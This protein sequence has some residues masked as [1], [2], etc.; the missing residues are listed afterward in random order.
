M[1]AWY[2]IY[3]H[4]N[5]ETKALG[6]LARQGFRA[7]LPR[8]EK[9]RRHAGRVETVRRPLFPRYLFVSLDVLHEPWRQILST[10]GVSDLVRHG[11]R[12]LALPAGVVEEIEQREADGAFAQA[13]AVR[14]LRIGDHVRIVHGAFADLV[15]RF[16]G[17]SDCERVFVLL[18]LLNR[19]VRAEVS[20]DAV[21]PA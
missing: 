3:T 19:Q 8:C 1:S 2:V 21:Q 15:G 4:A 12:P 6:H 13:G 16:F 9:R 18:D 14:A 5:S 10:I 7:Y 17:M 20:V 11:D